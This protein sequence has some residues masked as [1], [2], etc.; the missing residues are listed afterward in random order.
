M[1]SK[2]FL[3][4][5]HQLTSLRLRRFPLSGFQFAG[6][7][8]PALR[9]LNF[10]KSTNGDAYE[11]LILMPEFIKAFPNLAE[12][13][14][15]TEPST[16][17]ANAEVMKAIHDSHIKCVDLKIKVHQDEEFQVKEL[18]DRIDAKM[19]DEKDDYCIIEIISDND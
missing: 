2:D 3:N 1:S 9:K 16:L 4:S 19:E 12:L 15:F 13:S 10:S 11:E 7:H 14:L 8:Y 5:L 6:G 18:I 17:I